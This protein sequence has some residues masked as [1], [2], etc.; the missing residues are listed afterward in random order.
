MVT[1]IP[2]AQLREFIT[3][4]AE[5]AAVR[6]DLKLRLVATADTIERVAFGTYA[7]PA[8]DS[9]ASW[10]C[11]CPAV[12]AGILSHVGEPLIQLDPD[13]FNAL[14]DFMTVFD[15]RAVEL[16]YGDEPQGSCLEWMTWGDL[17][18]ID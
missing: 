2:R 17:E 5:R 7:Q 18:V 14:S 13:E 10:T 6:P 9:A 8:D 1:S 15:E 3:T 11:G 4:A 12:A 16:A